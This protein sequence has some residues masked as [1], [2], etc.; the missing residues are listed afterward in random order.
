M[1][2]DVASL[3]ENLALIGVVIMSILNHFQNK[4]TSAKIDETS[5]KID[6]LHTTTNGLSDKLA[7]ANLNLL[8]ET[9]ASAFAAGEKKERGDKPHD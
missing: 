5:A 8:N 9:R 6:V 4:T 2:H 7:K 1:L 3:A